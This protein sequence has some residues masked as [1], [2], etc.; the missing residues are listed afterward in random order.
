MNRI[1][2]KLAQRRKAGRGAFLPY[3]TAG[4]PDLKTTQ[5]LV[6]RAEKC[7]ASVVEIG[8]P[9][10]DSI[11]DGP[12][13]QESFWQA[14]D[15]GFRT[16]DGLDAIR[17]IRSQADIGL[18]AMI[19]YSLVFRIGAAAFIKSAAEAGIDGV[20]FPDVPV[21][22]AGPISRLTD[23]HGLCHIGLV[24]PTSDLERRKTIASLSSGFVYQIATA[25]TTG[26]R[27]STNTDIRSDIEALRG[28]TSLPI[29]VGFG[30]SKPEHVREVC[31]Y[32]DGAIVGSAI[33]RRIRDAIS[34][35]VVGEPLLD[36]IGAMLSGFGDATAR[37]D[38]PS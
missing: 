35:G 18:V 29:C 3:F 27:A 33:V 30:I 25:G 37:I 8:F 9:Y 21:E 24:A 20:I 10:S 34:E 13:I 19:S 11:A 31:T 22:E 28:H 23:Q 17:E 1:E 12:V 38:S 6:V 4:Y 26:E 7:G 2:Q 5:A 14:I 36:R 32:A 16:Q 15:G